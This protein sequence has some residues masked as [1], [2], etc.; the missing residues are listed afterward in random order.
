[1]FLSVKFLN[2]LRRAFISWLYF[3]I[4]LGFWGVLVLAGVLVWQR[5]PEQAFRDLGFLWGEGEQVWKMEKR[6]W[7]EAAMNGA[8]GGRAGAGFGS[9]RGGY[10]KGAYGGGR[11]W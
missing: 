5:G 9:Q 1:M 2:M 3:W 7:E 11:G 6:R 8:N 4:K 10:K